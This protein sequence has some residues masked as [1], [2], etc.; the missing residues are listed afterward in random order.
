MSSLPSSTVLTTRT[1]WKSKK[2]VNVQSCPWTLVS[3]QFGEIWCHSWHFTYSQFLQSDWFVRSTI[4]ILLS[5]D[6][7][8][9]NAHVKFW[10]RGGETDLA[11]KMGDLWFKIAVVSNSRGV[12][13]LSESFE[14]LYLSVMQSSSIQS[15]FG[16]IKVE[17]SH[18]SC[19]CY[20]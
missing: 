8:H 15:S 2:K 3:T 7:S 19:C 18:S 5:L 10:E 13:N 9:S 6:H 17:I 12:T 1:F 14:L 16:F 11:A 20:M 4:R